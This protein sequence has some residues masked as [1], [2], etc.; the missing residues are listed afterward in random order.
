MEWLKKIEGV[1]NCASIP[2]LARLGDQGV[3]LFFVLSGFLITYLLLSEKKNFNCINIKKFYM[4]RALRIWPLY[5]LMVF[6][7]FFVLPGV[8]VLNGFSIGLSDPEYWSKLFL[9]IFLGANFAYS[10]YPLVPFASQLWSVG[11]EEQFYIVWPH[12]VNRFSKYLPYI[13]VSIIIVAFAL[14]LFAGA[15]VHG[16][17][18]L[19]YRVVYHIIK[20]F[21][22]QNMAL[23]ALSAYLMIN[24][25]AGVKILLNQRIPE[26]INIVILVIS[27]ILGCRYGVFDYELYA[28]MYAILILY[29]A[30]GRKTVLKL[31]G[32]IPKYLGKIS[33]GLYVYH[34]TALKLAFIAVS[35]SI[36]FNAGSIGNIVYYVMGI[37]LS[38]IFAAVSYEVMERK[39]L[40]LKNRF[41]LIQSGEVH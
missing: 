9:F 1:K 37:T 12:V 20:H 31:E 10:V 32:K 29:G 6:L 41:S 39:F 30:A 4:R 3:S 11:V 15:A 17:G 33:Y 8:I 27:L 35:G 14:R 16:D 22:I 7:A 24:N 25:A 21:R 38:I 19:Q 23:G 28:I 34:I 5:Y 36:G 26:I 18:A 2:A 13:L 40:R